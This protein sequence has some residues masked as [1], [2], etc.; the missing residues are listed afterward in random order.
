MHFADKRSCR[1]FVQHTAQGSLM[2]L[3]QDA[4]SLACMPWHA[5]NML[6]FCA[7]YGTKM[8]GSAFIL[9]ATALSKPVS[10]SAASQS[11]AKTLQRAPRFMKPTCSNHPRCFTSLI[12]RCAFSTCFAS[13]HSPQ[14]HV[15]YI[16]G[17]W[18]CQTASTQHVGH[19]VER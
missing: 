14:A 5:Q 7:F 4:L 10:Y 13:G 15:A 18:S 9:H 6:H 12:V 2:F 11:I 1:L 8:Y 16:Q 17:A 3:Q 19:K